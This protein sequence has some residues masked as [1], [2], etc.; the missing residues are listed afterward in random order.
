MIEILKI[1][2]VGLLKYINS[3]EYRDATIV[4][5]SRHRAQSHIANP[6]AREH[7]VLL[8]LAMEGPVM[9]G[10]LGVLPDDFQVSDNDS[11]HI[12]WMSCLWVD[13]KHRGK[14]IAQQLIKTCFESWENKI[15]LTEFT[16]AAGKLYEKMG[17]FLPFLNVEGQRWYIKSTLKTIL[18]PKKEI[19]KRMTTL[20]SFIDISINLFLGIKTIFAYKSIQDFKYQFF[21]QINDEIRNFVDENSKNEMFRRRGNDLD[22]ILNYPWILSCDADMGISQIYHFSSVEQHFLCK[23]LEIRN[24]QGF[25]VGIVIFTV[26]NG[27]L[28]LPYIYYTDS[29]AFVNGILF[30]LKNF[31]I[32]TCTI[33]HEGALDA[34]RAKNVMRAISKKVTRKYLISSVLQKNIHSENRLLQDGDGDCAFT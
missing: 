2:K 25:L 17:I 16:E 28:R 11:L 23:G 27:H 12:G 5:I 15:L 20:L 34:I 21:S 32:K 1:D 19:F 14:K 7:D 6:K 10:Y 31:S 33:Y 18:P 4:P 9:V 24:Q 8:F 30:L 13:E 29:D 22:W 3:D 26:R